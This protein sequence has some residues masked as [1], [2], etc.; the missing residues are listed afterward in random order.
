MTNAYRAIGLVLSAVALL[1]LPS[2]IQAC[3]TRAESGAVSASVSPSSAD[4]IELVTAAVNVFDANSRPEHRKPFRIVEY[5]RDADG[6]VITVHPILCP[7][8]IA[9]GGGG[10]VRVSK[11]G[12]VRVIERYN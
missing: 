3:G 11:A 7:G 5:T 2:L 6:V 9:G 12:Q 10:R 4:S 1:A 8:R